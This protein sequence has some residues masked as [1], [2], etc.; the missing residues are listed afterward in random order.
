MRGG[1]LPAG[2]RSTVCSS[3]RLP[4]GRT[5]V[6]QVLNIGKHY[7][8]NFLRYLTEVTGVTQI[9]GLDIAHSLNCTCDMR[10]LSVNYLERWGKPLQITLLQGNA[11]DPDYRLIGCD[12]VIAIEMIQKLLPHDLDRLVHNVFGFIKPWVALFTTP[13]ADFNCLM[14]NLDKNGLRQS[15]HYFEWTREQLH[16]WC[17]N[18]VMR[19]PEYMVMSRGIGPGPVGTSHY[20]CFSQLVLF[21]SKHYYKKMELNV[22]S[23]VMVSHLPE[24]EQVSEIG[25]ISPKNANSSH[26]SFDRL[27]EPES[28]EFSQYS[29]E[30]TQFSSLKLTIQA[31]DRSVQC[32]LE[33]EFG[34][35]FVM[36]DDDVMYEIRMPR[37]R[38]DGDVYEIG[39]VASRLNNTMHY[40]KQFS[41]IT[42]YLM[43]KNEYNKMDWLDEILQ[44][45]DQLSCKINHRS[46]DERHVWN[47]VN[48]G[49]NVPYWNQYYKVV[50]VYNFPYEGRSEEDVILEVLS[51]E[52]NKFF[53]KHVRGSKLEIPVGALMDAVKHITDDVEKVIMLMEDSGYELE[54]ESVVYTG[55]DVSEA[56]YGEE[57]DSNFDSDSVSNESSSGLDLNGRL[58]NRTIARKI[59]M[60]RLMLPQ[61]EDVKQALGQVVC[62][63]KRIAMSS[64]PH[65]RGPA[66]SKWLQSKLLEL[67]TL[68]EKSVLRRSLRKNEIVRFKGFS[69][70]TGDEISSQLS[71]IKAEDDTVIRF[72]EKYEAILRMSA[73]N[74]HEINYEHGSDKSFPSKVTDDSK[75]SSSVD[76]SKLCD[77]NE[78]C[79]FPASETNDLSLSPNEELTQYTLD[80]QHI[81]SLQ[82]WGEKDMS[83]YQED[84][85]EI[86]NKK[87]GDAISKKQSKH[88]KSRRDDKGKTKTTKRKVTNSSN[89]SICKKKSKHIAVK[90]SPVHTSSN[91]VVDR[92]NDCAK[93]KQGKVMNKLTYNNTL[94]CI[95]TMRRKMGPTLVLSV[96][97]KPIPG[98]IL[99]L[100]HPHLHHKT[101]EPFQK[102]IDCW[103]DTV[104]TPEAPEAPV[105]PVAPVA[106]TEHSH[107]VE[108][109]SQSETVMVAL[110]RMIGT[111]PDVD[112]EIYEHE[113]ELSDLNSLLNDTTY[114][115]HTEKN[116]SPVGVYDPLGIGA[117]TQESNN[118]QQEM[119][120]FPCILKTPFVEIVTQ[121]GQELIALQRTIGTDP[122]VDTDEY[123]QEL[124]ESKLT[125]S[126][127]NMASFE[128]FPVGVVNA[129]SQEFFLYDL[130]EPTTSKGIRHVSMDVQC[131]TERQ[132]SATTSFSCPLKM[133]GPA[134][135]FEGSNH[136]V[137]AVLKN[138]CVTSTHDILKPCEP[139]ASPWMKSVGI[140]IKD[141]NHQINDTSKET[142]TFSGSFTIAKNSALIDTLRNLPV[143]DTLDCTKK[144]MP[145][146]SPS[147][148]GRLKWNEIKKK[149]S[150]HVVSRIL[151]V[152]K[153]VR[154]KLSCGGVHIHSY[155]DLQVSED[156]V[157]QGEWQRHRRYRNPR[158]SNQPSS[159][160]LKFTRKPSVPP[161][162]QKPIVQKTVVT[163]I[164]IRNTKANK[165]K[166]AVTKMHIQ[167]KL[168]PTTQQVPRNRTVIR[169]VTKVT[170]KSTVSYSKSIKAKSSKIIHPPRHTRLASKTT[171]IK[172]NTIPIT[173]KR[174][175][176]IPPYLEKMKKK[177]QISKKSSKIE[178]KSDSLSNL[179]NVNNE[180]ITSIPAQ[181]KVED[182]VSALLK[183]S[184]KPPKDVNYVVYRNE[185]ETSHCSAAIENIPVTARPRSK[186]DVLRRK[187]SNLSNNDSAYSSTNSATIALNPVIT[188]LH[189]FQSNKKTTAI[190]STIKSNIKREGTDS[191]MVS[192]IKKLAS[193]MFSKKSH[194]NVAEHL[195]KISTISPNCSK[196]SL[197]GD[198]L[199]DEAANNAASSEESKSS[200]TKPFLESYD[201]KSRPCPNDKPEG[202][203]NKQ[204]L[205][206][207]LVLDCSESNT[208]DL[209]TESCFDCSEAKS[210]TQESLNTTI[211]VTTSNK[212]SPRIF[213]SDVLSKA[214]DNMRETITDSSN[215]ILDEM[216]QLLEECLNFKDTSQVALKRDSE[217]AQL[218]SSDFDNVTPIGSDAYE[219][220][221]SFHKTYAVRSLASLTQSFTD[222]SYK[223]QPSASKISE[224]LTDESWYNIATS[225]PGSEVQSENKDTISVTQKPK[226]GLA[227]SSFSV[228]AQPSP[229]A[230]RQQPDYVNLVDSETGSC[231]QGARRATSEEV[232]VS[233]RSSDSY[234]SCSV[235]EDATIPSWLYNISQQPSGSF[236]SSRHAVLPE[237]VPE[238]DFDVNGNELTVHGAGAGDGCGIHSDQ[239][240]DSSGQGTSFSSTGSSTVH[241]ESIV[242][243]PASF[244]A[245]Y[246][247]P[248]ERSHSS[249]VAPPEELIETLDI[250]APENQN[251]PL[252]RNR[253]PRSIHRVSLPAS[254]ADISSIDTDVASD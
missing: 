208:R 112:A 78:V 14:K 22:N 8:I 190:K 89:S 167:A 206:T 90:R 220:S 87:Y 65:A 28:S 178:A 202:Y 46:G 198:L 229:L 95:D 187:L 110:Q 254:D 54:G 79:K 147:L 73:G 215:D 130:N 118:A 126:L 137:R 203:C 164:I 109:L 75:N 106:A 57:F 98:S 128:K 37:K 230:F 24:P 122:E 114:F 52:I 86:K 236:S 209:K 241:S 82:D 77:V 26:S 174:K 6:W 88:K 41:K 66:R 232:L 56:N 195:S 16:D 45:T 33:V 102:N 217:D 103:N 9:L 4:Y 19:Y 161:I 193:L 107:R 138:D 207:T 237:V 5:M 244:L 246:S 39:D 93:H 117:F 18:I 83:L 239:S 153:G 70:D 216:R 47:N 17:S 218:K 221:S 192:R 222:F 60:L 38:S 58:L 121:D 31:I 249:A 214:R 179:L 116:P 162:L 81:D 231:A 186:E 21:I 144:K 99:E 219:T 80:D 228:N 253:V 171:I 44:L 248:G 169:Q 245:D 149:D 199:L 42:Q 49:E 227:F 40:V 154:S 113:L 36:F 2:V 131:G 155:N 205:K 51:A 71:R 251:R 180:Q 7:D 160:K 196:L 34:K 32:N 92:K 20:G 25:W 184:I 3:L 133:F 158:K 252:N 23:L 124:G 156:V 135:D 194:T 101:A 173:Q 48:W 50:G 119:D 170:S 97:P 12:A 105:A 200:V 129:T 181:S 240:Q 176:Y 204:D 62:R 163:P 123:E 182:L 223:S 100:C 127:N 145:N 74:S 233:S 61:E 108:I 63:L 247:P 53:D 96:P 111:D 201:R 140:K 143:E 134:L 85:N 120:P 139:M 157:Y 64:G 213:V 224:G 183:V 238:L 15:D 43:E 250:A 35:K 243:D 197:K 76:L 188:N 132:I 136:D 242:V 59:K 210:D 159:E 177:Q 125:T 168:A 175:V 212:S 55:V 1:I 84:T 172:E 166:Q 104:G 94:V 152:P 146:N 234:V 151:H 150:N 11:A 148:Y 69:Y 191:K 235:E 189:P 10:D 27:L 185:M 165:M 91:K 67:M 225:R 29:S 68:T 13:N 115:A 141:S 30:D 72:L 142:E 211:L 226:S